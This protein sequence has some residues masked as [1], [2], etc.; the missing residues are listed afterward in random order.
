MRRPTDQELLRFARHKDAEKKSGNAFECI[1]CHELCIGN[2]H[3]AW[4]LGDGV[5]CNFCNGRW[6]IQA[7]A[8]TIFAE[9]LGDA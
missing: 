8:A 7:R 1:L 6:V 2:G 3:N 5:C 4:P 9:P